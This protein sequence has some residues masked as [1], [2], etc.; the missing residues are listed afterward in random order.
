M[1]PGRRLRR[2]IALAVVVS[3]STACAGPPGPSTPS[4][5][6]TP[7]TP[8]FPPEEL[9]DR[10]EALPETS[11]R[12]LNARRLGEGLIPPTNRWFSG[13]VFGE[14][15]QPIFPLPLS[16]G[17][18]ED[19]FAFGVPEVTTT[20]KTIMGGYHPAVSVTRAGSEWEVAAYDDA[21][22]TL[23]N[24]AGSTVGVAEGSPY[25][26][27]TAAEDVSLHTE[28][29]TWRRAG[30]YATAEVAGTTYGLV[31]TGAVDGS[32]VQVP[33]GGQAVWFAI[34]TGGDPARMAELAA[35]VTGTSVSYTVADR[36][37]TT[38]TYATQD[39]RPTVLAVMPH[40][41]EGLSDDLDCTLGRWPSIYGTLTACAGTQITWS[42]PTYPT[43]AGLDLSRLTSAQSEELRGE[44][45]A[46]VA[47][48]PPPPADTYFGGKAL[49]R[50][51]QLWS[52]AVQLGAD[53]E[54]DVL[55]ERMITAL[56]R[57]TDPEGCEE[58]D[59]A[60]CFVY[61]ARNRGIVGRTP[62]FGSDEYNDHHFHYGYFLYAAGVL[63]AD[64]AGLAARWAP[65]MD[66]LAADIAQA[67]ASELL[68]QRRT[69]DVYASHSWASGTSPFADG[70]NQESSSEA[71]N[72]WAGLTL[73]AQASGNTILEAE[74]RWMHA[75]EAQAARAYWTD[76][77]DTD[78]VYAGF[79]HSISPLNFGGKRDY[80]TWFSPEPA[81]ALAILVIPASPSADHLAGDPERIRANVAEA[82]AR[83]GFDQTYGGYLLMYS[84]LAGGPDREDALAT[85]RDLS[86]EAIDDG[87][88][89]TYL[90][91]FLMSLA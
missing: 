55:R 77:D 13:L 35:P 1:R 2:L 4:V 69:F 16:F 39:D 52:I 47:A 73:W 3:V 50:D 7:T 32:R 61:D 23:S 67:P 44:L 68:P 60:F 89:R 83:G 72:A 70:N 11:G 62:S 58:Q 79:D 63:A 56:D 71:V 34:P 57:W 18:T 43:R 81:A 78:P 51:A 29:L 42:A 21:S 12:S 8:A 30:G 49:Y 45:A 36:A 22:V 80:A 24:P 88:T 75:L 9:A 17:L 54:A 82:T 27:Y 5:P 28:G 65:V 53:A 19:G 76:F 91:A 59:A 31:T 38:L 85:A 40:Q 86:D 46:D 25:V 6:A 41:Q 37:S 33:R 48:V 66:L 84:A 14:E 15:P 26:S 64:D 74:A 90:L 10:V 20:E 87:I